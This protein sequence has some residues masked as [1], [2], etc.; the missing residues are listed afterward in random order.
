MALALARFDEI[1]IPRIK[2]YVTKSWVT[3]EKQPTQNLGFGLL[4]SRTEPSQWSL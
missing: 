3:H 2:T 4:A 1:V